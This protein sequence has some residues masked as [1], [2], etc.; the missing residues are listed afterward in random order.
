MVFPAVAVEVLEA[1]VPQEVGS[2]MKKDIFFNNEECVKIEKSIEEV[3]KTTSGELVVMA[4]KSSGDY[5]IPIVFISYILSVILSILILQFLPLIV[6]EDTITSLL[7][8]PFDI[9]GEFMFALNFGLLPFIGLNVLL[10]L[11]FIVLFS[12]FKKMIRS[13][14][15]H[16]IKE[17]SV[18]ERVFKE[19]YTRGLH[20]T[21]DKTG[22]LIMLSVVERLVYILAD[23]GIY[24]KISQ[25]KLNAFASNITDK[26]KKGNKADGVIETINELNSVLK[27]YFPIKSD[28]T[29]ELS[30]KVIQID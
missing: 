28:D 8:Q 22:I 25:D 14:I 16:S 23:Q 1:V 4:V 18:K 13:F 5:R 6:P 20:N 19:F 12:R 21:R 7:K 15:P 11:T 30:N 3:E 9:R 24:E 2:L 17:E 27:I 10:M 29:N 26:I